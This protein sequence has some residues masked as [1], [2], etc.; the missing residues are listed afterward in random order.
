MSRN[1]G[2]PRQSVASKNCGQARHAVYRRK[3][4]SREYAKLFADE[5]G[6]P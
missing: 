3:K 5:G 2:S 4:P 6:P 1:S